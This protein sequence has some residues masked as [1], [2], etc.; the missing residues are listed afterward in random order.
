MLDHG[1]KKVI[2]LLHFESWDDFQAGWNVQLL[3]E[4]IMPALANVD[5]LYHPSWDA[6]EFL[7]EQVTHY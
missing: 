1:H 4:T 7:V 3:I 2:K 5:T 6:I